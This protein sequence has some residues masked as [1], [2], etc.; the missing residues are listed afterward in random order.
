M[1]K[2][3]PELQDE[4][5]EQSSQSNQDKQNNQQNLLLD[6]GYVLKKKESKLQANK[7]REVKF[8]T[9]GHD[10]KPYHAKGLCKNCY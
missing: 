6:D 10:D 9:C 7:L 2:I 4:S 1:K 5:D 8:L 3:D